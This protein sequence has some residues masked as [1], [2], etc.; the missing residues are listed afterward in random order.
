MLTAGGILS[1]MGGVFEVIGGGIMVGLVIAHRQL[2]R[3]G[4]T[5][6]R[7]GI[8]SG[9]FGP[10]ELIWLITVGVSLLVLG[11]IA[12]VGGVSAIR[13]RIFGLSLAGAICTLPSVIFG[14]YLGAGAGA[15]T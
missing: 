6:G 4:S 15:L 2:L 10:V 5:T 3:P 12:T 7:P 11:I 13:K 9:L 14:L 8:N 1:I